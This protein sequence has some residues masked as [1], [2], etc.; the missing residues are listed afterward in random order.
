MLQ[1][2][3]RL[4]AISGHWSLRGKSTPRPEAR[5]GQAT[6]LQ[7]VVGAAHLGYHAA[8]V[9]ATRR[10]SAAQ[11]RAHF[12]LVLPAPGW[13]AGGPPVVNRWPFGHWPLK[14]GPERTQPTSTPI[15]L[16]QQGEEPH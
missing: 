12:S 13:W 14:C 2:L 10:A 5:V 11:H 15:S 8:A 1:E 4:G 9:K 3:R 16:I 7:E 6:G